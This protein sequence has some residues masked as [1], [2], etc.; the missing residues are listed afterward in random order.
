MIIPQFPA[1]FPLPILIVQHM[2]PLFTRFLAERL[3]SGT[4]L[5]V[6]EA[7]DGASVAAGTVLIAPGDYHMRVRS[8]DGATVVRTGPIAA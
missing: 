1:N 2:P 6:E 7:T 3:Q 8:Q 5:N 4:Q